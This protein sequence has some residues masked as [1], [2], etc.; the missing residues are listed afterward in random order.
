MVTL[1]KAFERLNLKDNL[2]IVYTARKGV[3]PTVFYSF[4]KATGMAEKKLAGLLHVHPRTIQNYRDRHMSLAPV[5]SEHLLKLIALFMKGEALFGNVQEFSNWL[6]KTPWNTTAKFFTD[7]LITPG[8][9]DL[10]TAELDRLS[11]GYPV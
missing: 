1:Q 6:D 11:E 8:G 10:M 2:S 4:A 9:I 3:K 5:E 7:L